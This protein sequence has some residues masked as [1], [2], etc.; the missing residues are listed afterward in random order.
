MSSPLID[1]LVDDYGY[2]LLDGDSFDGFV[3]RQPYSLLFF[4]E[5]PARFPESND[6]A[7]ILPEL[8]K[9]FPQ[10][11]VAVIARSAEKALQGRYNFQQW[12]TLVLLKQGR[13]LGQIS[14]VQN[15]DDYLSEIDRMLAL[16]PSRNPGIGIPVVVNNTGPNG[17]GA[18]GCGH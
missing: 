2:P 6:L 18:P 1:R 8:V 14:R 3:E 4:S 17:V 11:S 16:E 7:V 10:L 9:A 12:P 13:Y 5:A 15:W